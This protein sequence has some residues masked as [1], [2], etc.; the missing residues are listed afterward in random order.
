V[1]DCPGAASYLTYIQVV[2]L[3]VGSHILSMEPP[4]LC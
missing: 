2:Y 3:E 1:Q 4:L